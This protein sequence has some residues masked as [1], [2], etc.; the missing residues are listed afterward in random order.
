MPSKLDLSTPEECANFIAAYPTVKG[1]RLAK[2]L[3]I[4]GKGS[5]RLADAVS[6]LAWNAHV[7][8]TCKKRGDAL[9][10][11]IYG[12]SAA[13]CLENIAASP[14]AESLAQAVKLPHANTYQTL[15]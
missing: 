5:S 11:R 14:L 4:A 12:H 13:I 3:G 10:A 6:C 15:V 2:I 1:R 7:A 8:H 9:G